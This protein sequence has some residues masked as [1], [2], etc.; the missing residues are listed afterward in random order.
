MD[1]LRPQAANISMAD[2]LARLS[3]GVVRRGRTS[4]A[5]GIDLMN[6]AAWP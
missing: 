3:A 5:R 6:H 1:A 2:T 4:C